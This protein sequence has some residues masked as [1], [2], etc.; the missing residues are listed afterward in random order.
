MKKAVL[1]TLIVLLL[2]TGTAGLFAEE[3]SLVPKTDTPPVIDGILDDAAWKTAMK[4]EEYKTIQPDSGKDP[5]QKSI[6]YFTYDEENLY[7]AVRSYDSKPEKIKASVSA[8]DAMFQDDYV[9]IMLDT[10]NTMQDGFGF[11]LNPLGIQGDGMITGGGN[12]EP[13]FDMIWESKGVIDDKG[14]SV[15]AR[16]PLK[17]KEHPVSQGRHHCY[18][19]GFFSSGGSQ[20]RI[21]NLSPYASRKREPAQTGSSHIDFRPEIQTCDRTPSGFDPQHPAVPPEWLHENRR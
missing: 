5:S 13:S 3:A 9:A 14:Y 20:F 6:A 18:A 11:F 8:R 7:F 21:V 2:I 10:F 12:L 4:F 19:P 1:K 16:I 17:S 15:E